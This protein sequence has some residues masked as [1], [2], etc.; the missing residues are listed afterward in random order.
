V[1]TSEDVLEVLSKYCGRCGLGFFG[2]WWGGVESSSEHG[3][4]S[5]GCV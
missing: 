2:P 4:V 3:N 1:P 5:S